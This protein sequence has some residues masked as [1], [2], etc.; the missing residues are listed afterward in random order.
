VR[1][2]RRLAPDVYR[3]VAALRTDS[4]GELTLT[5]ERTDASGEEGD[6]VEWMVHMRRLPSP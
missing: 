3:G 6:V 2:N 1:L 5:G 4:E